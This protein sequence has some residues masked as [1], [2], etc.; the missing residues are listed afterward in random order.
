MAVYLMCVYGDASVRTWFEKAYKQSGKKLDMGQSC[1][2]FKALDALPL[3]LI[4]E[5]VGK[6][7]VASYVASYRKIRA[8]TKPMKRA[9]IAKKSAAKAAAKKPAAKKTAVKKSAAKQ[10]GT[11]RR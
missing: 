6:V 5:A 4:G 7:S 1:V 8:E 3:E 10:T 9:E 2:R 11:K